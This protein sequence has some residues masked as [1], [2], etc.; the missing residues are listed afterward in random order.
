MDLSRG[1]S[2]RAL[3]NLPKIPTLP[4]NPVVP[5]STNGW[6]PLA[7]KCATSLP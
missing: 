2:Q 7:Q 6:I 1:T 4:K 3:K 5:H